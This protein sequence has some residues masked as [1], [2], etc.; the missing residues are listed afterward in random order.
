MR[1]TAI[2]L[3]SLGIILFSPSIVLAEDSGASARPVLASPRGKTVSCQAR[4]DAVTKRSVQLTQ[5][6]QK[7]EDNFGKIAQ[8]VETYYTTKLTASGVTVANYSSLVSDIAAKKAA[9]D[10]ALTDAQ[11]KAASFSCADVASAK[12]Q[13]QD[14]RIAMQKVIRALKEYK[15]SVKNLIVAVRT[16]AGKFKPSSS[17]TATP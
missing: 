4:M 17:P 15:T 6:A 8:K 2:A 13:V 7:M 10:A 1:K 5:R 14:F 12:T 3:L 11:S 9:V 16:A